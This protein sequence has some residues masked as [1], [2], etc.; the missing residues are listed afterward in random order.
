MYRAVKSCSMKLWFNSLIKVLLYIHLGVH[1]FLTPSQF[2]SYQ[3]FRVK[4]TVNYQIF[5]LFFSVGGK[6]SY[7]QQV[8]SQQSGNEE[9]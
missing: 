3:D 4:G 8:P 6:A 7:T 1:C 9:T 5:K 2:I